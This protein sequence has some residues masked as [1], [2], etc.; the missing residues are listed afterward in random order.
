M[1][2]SLKT[3]VFRRNDVSLLSEATPG[4]YGWNAPMLSSALR[5]E[6]ISTDLYKMVFGSCQ[7]KGTVF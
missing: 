3:F 1:S 7:G 6:S 2:S 4:T 5:E